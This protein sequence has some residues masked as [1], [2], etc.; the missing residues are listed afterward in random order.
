MVPFSAFGQ[1]PDLVLVADVDHRPVLEVLGAARPPGGLKH[2]V[3]VILGDGTV[4]VST[5]G[6]Q[7]EDASVRLIHGQPNYRGHGFSEACDSCQFFDTRR[8]TSPGSRLGH[9]K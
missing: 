5:D 3:E 7:A 2:S 4:L 6:P 1:A 9:P 8:A